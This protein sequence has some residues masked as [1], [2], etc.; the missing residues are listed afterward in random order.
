MDMKD[1]VKNVKEKRDAVQSAKRLT[2]GFEKKETE[3][4]V[5]QF[6]TKEMPT[7]LYFG[8]MRYNVRVYA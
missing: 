1:L 2:R 4:V 8:Y 6:S 3:S 7:A 5:I